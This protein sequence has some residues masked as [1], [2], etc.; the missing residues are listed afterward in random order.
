MLKNKIINTLVS[1]SFILCA[2]LTSVHFNCFD[3]SFYESEHNKL[4]IYGRSIAEH[5]GINDEE[6]KELT[7]FT[8]AYL[9][10]KDLSLDKQMNINGKL[11][12]VFTDDEKLHMVDV[13]NLNLWSIN[14]LIIS[15][16]VFI[17]CLILILILKID[18]YSLYKKYIEVLIYT[19]IFFGILSFF[20]LVDFDS[21]WTM[22]HKIFFTSNELWLL[23]LNTDILI[24]IVPPEFFNH[25][26]IRIVLM[27]IISIIVFGVILKLISK[28]KKYIYD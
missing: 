16:I 20:I 28:R 21:F 24:M 4:K 6:L 13:R 12:E 25:L 1:I 5:I 11:R 2:L 7:S 8:L 19:L 14:I 23:D 22:F 3:E 17:I 15:F 10:D 26:V 9:N 18:V 27:F